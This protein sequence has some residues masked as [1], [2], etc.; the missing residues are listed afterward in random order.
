MVLYEVSVQIRT[1][2][3]AAFEHYMRTKHIPEIW[4]TGCFQQIYFDQA[5][6]G[7]YRTSYQA[8]NLADYERY[9]DQY[10]TAMRADFMQHFPEGCTV[11]RQVLQPL[12]VWK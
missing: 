6:S 8:A 11:T 9:I 12:Q 3:S 4:D 10:A 2:L 1:D 7:A 5:D